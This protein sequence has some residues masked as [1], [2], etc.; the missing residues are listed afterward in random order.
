MRAHAFVFCLIAA[1]PAGNP[2]AFAQTAKVPSYAVSS[3]A[4]WWQT[5][6][7]SASS[8]ASRVE[9]I[10]RTSDSATRRDATTFEGV[11]AAAH[12][13]QLNRAWSLTTAA[14]LT[15]F[16]EPDFERNDFTS[17]AGRLTLQHKAGLG[18][19]APVIQW[20]TSVLRHQADYASNRGNTL[21]STIRFNRRV[22][23]SLRASASAH[24]REHFAR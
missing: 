18:P 20:D 8:A 3:P 22:S 10:S 21:E 23:S 6:R 5:V 12:H 7:V 1:I 13:R 11:L 17:A 9:N 16:H 19:M 15:V 4:P 24:W 14:D 2:V